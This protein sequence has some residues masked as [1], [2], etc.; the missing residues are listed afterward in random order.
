MN[1]FPVASLD[2]AFENFFAGLVTQIGVEQIS[3]GAVQ[4][5]NFGEP[6]Q[7]RAHPLQGRQLNFGKTALLPGGVADRMNFTIGK[8]QRHG[9]VISDTL[10]PQ[11]REDFL[12]VRTLGIA[13]LAANFDAFFKYFLQGIV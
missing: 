5:I 6:R 9:N 3:R 12:V 13:Q 7:G 4:G 1:I 11:F 10:R 2:V 8:I